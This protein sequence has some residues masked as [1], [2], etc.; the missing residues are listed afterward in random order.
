MHEFVIVSLT[1]LAYFLSYDYFSYI[2]SLGFI[3][4][5]N[6]VS[7][8]RRANAQKVR[9]YY[10]YWQYT[11]LK[12]IAEFETRVSNSAIRLMYLNLV[13]SIH[14][15]LVYLSCINVLWYICFR[16]VAGTVITRCICLH[17]LHCL[18]IYMR[19]FCIS[20]GLRAVR[21]IP[22]SAILCYHRTNL[23]YHRVNLCFQRANFC[24][25]RTNLGYQCKLLL[26]HF[27]RKKPPRLCTLLISTE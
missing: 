19:K 8:W 2:N 22:N 1:W 26:S 5:F 15:T 12:R 17:C 23:C 10:P 6:S 18:I 7:L 14:V 11:N 16:T 27:G 24:Y 13:F 21:L 3:F 9:L 20:V 25:H 4:L